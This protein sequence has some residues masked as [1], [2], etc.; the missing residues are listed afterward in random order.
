MATVP[1][2]LRG[3][4]STGEPDY[5]K[6]LNRVITKDTNRSVV[7]RYAQHNRSSVLQGIFSPFVLYLWQ[8]TEQGESI[9]DVT[10]D[11]AEIEKL[12]LSFEAKIDAKLA[13]DPADDDNSCLLA[14]WIVQSSTPIDFAT[15]PWELVQT[16]GDPRSPLAYKYRDVVKVLF[17]KRYMI[18]SHLIAELPAATAFSRGSY[19]AGD[20]INLYKDS[21]GP[22]SVGTAAAP[23]AVTDGHVYAVIQ[24]YYSEANITGFL[25]CVMHDS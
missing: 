6:V 21:F 13:G 8:N 12:R 17:Y 19:G 1:Q 15:N 24:P 18:N 3:L 14:V 9:T 2:W 22:V 20:V 16:A 7:R 10:G 5:E 23:N 4:A 11:S 25:S